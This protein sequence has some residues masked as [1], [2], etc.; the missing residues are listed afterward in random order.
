MKKELSKKRTVMG[1][2]NLFYPILA[3]YFFLMAMLLF[4]SL[5][6]LGFYPFKLFLSQREPTSQQS[7][8]VIFFLSFR[9]PSE[10]KLT[11]KG[12]FLAALLWFQK[13]TLRTEEYASLRPP[14]LYWQKKKKKKGLRWTR[15]HD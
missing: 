7:G 14:F 6:L 13:T 1:I 10:G 8:N 5:P 9:T 4:S 15:V 3:Q 2:S 11:E 12:S